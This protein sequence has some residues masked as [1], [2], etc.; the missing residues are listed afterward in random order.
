MIEIKIFFEQHKR[1]DLPLIKMPSNK[2]AMIIQTKRVFFI[3]SIVTDHICLILSRIV[4]RGRLPFVDGGLVLTD[5]KDCKELDV[6][7]DVIGTEF[8][9][10]NWL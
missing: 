6:V 4:W 9:G 1:L 10:V 3:N 7:E 2:F 8:V 5:G